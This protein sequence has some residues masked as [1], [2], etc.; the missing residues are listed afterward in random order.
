VQLDKTRIAIRERNFSEILDLGLKVTR[1]HAVPLAQALA[2]GALPLVL[3]NQLLVGWMVGE[4]YGIQSISLHVATMGLLVFLEAPL[5]SVPITIYLGKEMFLVPFRLRDVAADLRT[6][7]PALFVIQLVLRGNLAAWI[8][9]GMMDRQVDFSWAYLTFV[10]LAGC[11]WWV[12]AFRPFVNEVILLERSRLRGA[13]RET[14]DEEDQSKHTVQRRSAVLHQPYS[15]DVFVRSMSAACVAALLGTVLVAS[16]WLV[17]GTLLNR[18]SWGPVM[19]HV[20]VPL[21]MWLVAG[22]L[23]VVR[24]LSYLDLRIRLEGWEVELLVRAAANQLAK[25]M[26]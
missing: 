23:S 6:A 4:E 15:G 16:L 13:R 21:A 18:W 17:S 19:V 26:T 14:S 1:V 24:F 22:Y 5:A 2:V 8:L 12:R 7:S 25:Q 20:A 9:L 3:I 10:L 11:V